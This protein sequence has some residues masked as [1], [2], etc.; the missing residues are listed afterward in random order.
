MSD[1]VGMVTTRLVSE[2][3]RG[4]PSRA[5]TTIETVTPGS[6]SPNAVPISPLATRSCTLRPLISVMWSPRASPASEAGLS[7]KHLQHAQLVGPRLRRDAHAYELAV[8]V[9]RLVGGARRDVAERGVAWARADRFEIRL[10]RGVVGGIDLRQFLIPE[11]VLVQHG[12]DI[13]ILAGHRAVARTRLRRGGHWQKQCQGR[14]G[15]K[16]WRNACGTGSARPGPVKFPWESPHFCQTG[17]QDAAAR[18]R[19]R[20]S[21]WL[22]LTAL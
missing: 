2:T 6:L 8:A 14:A 13:Q 5:R 19:P 12:P 10:G 17:E 18:C 4:W 21:A 16:E 20:R 15:A 11:V 1:T 7:G 3:C 22:R 9:E